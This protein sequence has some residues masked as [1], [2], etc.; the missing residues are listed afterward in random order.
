MT[1]RTTSVE[2][3]FQ[4]IYLSDEDKEAASQQSNASLVTILLTFGSSLF[5]QIALGGTIEA[6]WLLFGT[7]QL[8]SLVPLFHLNLP[9]NFREFAK[10]LAILHGEPQALPNLFSNYV[11]VDELEP[12]NNYFELMS[13]PIS[14]IF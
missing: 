12:Y 2:I 11:D 7:I 9:S 4:F 3:P 13:M 10:N 8:M 5:L 1:T 6:T 14:I